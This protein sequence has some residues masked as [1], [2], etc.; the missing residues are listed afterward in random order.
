M[1][2][3]D[4]G[5][6]ASTPSSSNHHF[7][8][9]LFAAV[10]KVKFFLSRACSAPHR[11][12]TTTLQKYK[13]PHAHLSMTHTVRWKSR[14]QPHLWTVINTEAPIPV[15]CSPFW[16]GHF[17]SLEFLIR[18]PLLNFLQANGLSTRVQIKWCIPFILAE[19]TFLIRKTTKN[20]PK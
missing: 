7:L 4:F 18:G 9:F 10:I 20:K 17:F 2:S 5:C 12:P 3:S 16:C 14:S 8:I 15:R 13:T 11:I 1:P 19:E 6:A